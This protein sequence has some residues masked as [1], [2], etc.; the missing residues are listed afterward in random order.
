MCFKYNFIFSYK[1]QITDNNT[2][3]TKGTIHK[4]T[5]PSTL[6]HKN[7][8][9]MG[10][11]EKFDC[12]QSFWH[13][14]IT[15]E[16]GWKCWIYLISSHCTCIKKCLKRSPLID[17]PSIKTWKDKSCLT[18]QSLSSFRKMLLCLFHFERMQY[19]GAG[20]T[21]QNKLI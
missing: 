8:Y 3:A 11:R 13:T 15:M 17:T 16:D 10:I 4:A 14:V 20:H 9:K 19:Y 12:S 5:G 18:M 2:S 1:L 21:D 6:F 7:S